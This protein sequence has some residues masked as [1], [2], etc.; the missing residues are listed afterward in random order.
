MCSE[1]NEKKKKKSPMGEII[2]LDFGGPDRHNSST[3][4]STLLSVFTHNSSLW[5]HQFPAASYDMLWRPNVSHSLETSPLRCT[6]NFLLAEAFD[7][8]SNR[9][10][11]PLRMEVIKERKSQISWIE[12]H[13]RSNNVHSCLP[14]FLVMFDCGLKWKMHLSYVSFV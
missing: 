2:H 9:Y 6:V 3:V 8:N 11:M 14:D 5:Q 4:T 13:V 10:L 12:F 1:L 7:N